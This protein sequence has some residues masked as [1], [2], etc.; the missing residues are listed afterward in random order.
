M[1]II[2]INVTD[3]ALTITNAPMI[4][5]G[6][7]KTDHVKFS[8]DSHWTGYGKTAV[9]YRDDDKEN[10]K[11]VALDVNNQAVIPHEITQEDGKIWIGVVGVKS[12]GQTLTS[13]VIWYEIVDGVY[14]GAMASRS[15][16]ASIY[17]RILEVFEEM[18][19]AVGSPLISNTAEEMTDQTKVYVYTGSEEGYTNGNWYYYNGSEWVS[20][21]VYNSFALETDK[22]FSIYGKA[23]DA[24]RTGEFKQAI[25]TARRYNPDN[26]TG[27]YDIVSGGTSSTGVLVAGANRART[28]LLFSMPTKI[29]LT[30]NTYMIHRVWT[31]RGTTPNRCI[32]SQNEAGENP[33]II[34]H[35]AEETRF[36]VVFALTADPT[37]EL[38]ETDYAA[39]SERF[40]AYKLTDNE[41]IQKNVP[42]DSFAVGIRF[43]EVYTAILDLN[44]AAIEKIDTSNFGYSYGGITVTGKSDSNWNTAK[45]RLRILNDE[46]LGGFYVAAG[47]TI[48][49]KDGYKFNVALCSYYKSATDFE[50]T[51]FRNTDGGSYTIPYDCYIRISIGTVNDDVL[52]TESA[53]AGRSLTEAGQTAINEAL[54][55]NLLGL[56]AIE[57]IDEVVKNAEIDVK[58]LT[59]SIPYTAI[60]Y[61]AQWD[62][63]VEDGFCERSDPQYM[64]FDTDHLYPLYAYKI[65]ANKDWLNS[66]YQNNQ[67]D[68]T[69]ET[70]L[71]SR[72]K[73]LITSGFHGSERAT[74]NFI[75]EFVNNLF[76]K[77]EYAEILC[78]FDWTIIP[79]VNPWG[80][81][82]S[83][84]K[85]GTVYHGQSWEPEGYNLMLNSAQNQYNGGVRFNSS[86]YDC[87]RDFSDSDYTFNGKVYGFKTA[88]AQFVKNVF[89]SEKFDI[90]VDFHQAHMNNLC[91]FVSFANSTT[92]ELGK[93]IYSIIA[94]VGAKTDRAMCA[95][96]D[97]TNGTQ[98]SYPWSGTV[99]AT[100]RNYSG[101]FSYDGRGNTE[102][103]DKSAKYA[104]CLET[105]TACT[106]YSDTTK[107][108]TKAANDYGNTFTDNFLNIFLDKANFV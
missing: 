27:L 9:F 51:D 79:L 94:K 76:R 105:S 55:F 62:E 60:E 106:F 97:K 52:W 41:L 21:G 71:Y 17:S 65:K 67:Y 86:G 16:E 74:P 31:Y 30:D 6:D 64:S 13:E 89:L 59:K 93:E 37:Q 50:L 47:S 87:N 46:G 100:F 10:I 77:S 48:A 22:K 7:I 54:T 63:M 91:G 33:V 80:Y 81:S 82:H 58:H 104:L 96:Y 56:T 61:H 42:A 8:F 70:E 20:G 101:G 92:A 36:V 99:S 1:S 12:N 73:I 78:A 24:A 95:A 5:A 69:P 43:S 108:Y 4:S 11:E 29:E 75:W 53:E 45:A 85:N 19:A 34:S 103:T 66:S 3:Q 15:A 44:A 107:P 26:D 38:N 28:I 90:V 32:V 35:D 39:I 2:S 18:K 40:R 84:V 83:Y 68:G 102:H 72:P 98:T 23:A 57:K 14:T 49:A 88:E 25:I